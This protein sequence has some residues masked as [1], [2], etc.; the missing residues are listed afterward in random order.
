MRVLPKQMSCDHL[1]PRNTVNELEFVMPNTSSYEQP[2]NRVLNQSIKIIH[3]AEHQP[4]V[5][6][7]HDVSCAA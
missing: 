4:E 2:N 5:A 7:N 6:R 3:D 1:N